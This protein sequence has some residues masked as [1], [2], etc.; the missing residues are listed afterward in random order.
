MLDGLNERIEDYD[1][2]TVAEFFDMAGVDG[3]FTDNRYGWDNLRNAKVRQVRRG[4]MIE[5]PRPIALD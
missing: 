4:Y 1:V 5:L 2:V 3:E